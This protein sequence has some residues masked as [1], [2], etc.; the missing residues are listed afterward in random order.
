MRITQ[1]AKSERGSAVYHRHRTGDG[2]RARQAS[3]LTPFLDL[4]FVP[5][6]AAACRSL[7]RRKGKE[8]ATFRH[9]ESTE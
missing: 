1:S 7:V 8:R 4:R 2:G 9:K 3:V 6:L 5:A